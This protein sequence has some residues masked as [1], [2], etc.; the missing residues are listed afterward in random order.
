MKLNVGTWTK[1]EAL[2]SHEECAVSCLGEVLVSATGDIDF[3]QTSPV[4]NIQ[5]MPDVRVSEADLSRIGDLLFDRAEQIATACPE[6][7]AGLG[8]LCVD[9]AE[10]E[11]CDGMEGRS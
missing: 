2:C 5:L 3:E 1:V 9:C 8:H 4:L 7:Q 10:Q 11:F 6:C